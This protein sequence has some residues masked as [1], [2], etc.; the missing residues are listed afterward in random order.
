M[1]RFQVM[2]NVH[3]AKKRRDPKNYRAELFTLEQWHWLAEHYGLTQ[4]QKEILTLL[5]KGYT[6]RE[7]SMRLH[8]EL[9][10]VRMHLRGIYEKLGVNNRVRAVV[11][12]VLAVRALSDGKRKT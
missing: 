1:G 2:E 7:I 8:K 5:C 12:L 9:D 3:L 10:T 4:R 6:N 11:Q